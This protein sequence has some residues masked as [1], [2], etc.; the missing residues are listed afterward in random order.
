[1]L[2]R[3]QRSP[4]VTA[5]RCLGCALAACVAAGPLCARAQGRSSVGS[6][7]ARD[8]VTRDSAGRR[9]VRLQPTRIVGVQ[10]RQGVTRLEG[11]SAGHVYTGATT[12]LLHVDVLPANTANSNAREVLGHVPGVNVSE[13]RGGGFPSDG[14][15][16]RGLD[17]R[18][19]IEVNVRQNGTNVAGDLYGYPETYYSPPLEAVDHIEVVR[20]PSGL[21]YGPQFG[22]MVD[23]VLKDG[24]PNTAPAVSVDQTGASFGEYDG[25]ASVGGGSGRFTYY[26]FGHY[27]G[28]AGWRQNSNYEEGSGYAALTYR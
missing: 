18:Q 24:E 6:A 1:M 9:I 5:P 2:A 7:P 20:G 21:E 11:D 25:F 16:F 10:P 14:V 13:T 23:Y 8:S 4:H 12:T 15:A 22:G 28:A 27:Q 26:A 19:S 17:P 3:P